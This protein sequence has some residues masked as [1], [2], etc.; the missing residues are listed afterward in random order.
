M[1]AGLLPG[2][3]YGVLAFLCGA[4]LGPIRELLLAPEIGALPAALLEGVVLAVALFVVARVA[5]RRLPPEAGR[6]PRAAM[7]VLGVVVVL[8]GEVA[9]GAVLD[10]SGLSEGRAPRGGAEQ[11]IGL[12]LLAWLAALPFRVRR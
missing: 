7:A 9:L 5:A 2:L 3:L 1:K 11:A 12:V 6:D 4:V 10:A 8:A